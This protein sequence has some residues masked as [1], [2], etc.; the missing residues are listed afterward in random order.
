MQ[1]QGLRVVG[2]ECPPITMILDVPEPG[3]Y[4]LQIWLESVYFHL[5]AH[6]RPR[7]A[8]RVPGVGV[9]SIVPDDQPE[10]RPV[11]PDAGGSGSLS[12][13]EPDSPTS[14]PVVRDPSRDA[15]LC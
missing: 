1:A 9:M 13:P 10:L 2:P 14:R 5:P 4:R 11:L 7:N 15:A 3:R 8:W 12:A 6:A